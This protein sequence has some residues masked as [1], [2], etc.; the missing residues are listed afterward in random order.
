M[1]RKYAPAG[2]RVTLICP[3]C[4]NSFA[5]APAVAE[6]RKYCSRQCANSGANN[7]RWSGGRW[8]GSDGYVLIT[9]PGRGRIKEHRY[10]MEQMIGSPLPAGSV[11]HHRNGV[12]TDNRP[13]NLELMS[14]S[15]HV[16]LHRLA[17]GSR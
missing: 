1:P 2:T 10:V 17:G 5:L 13:E 3:H 8:I 16:R 6:R 4:G 9:V 15:E 14:N 11:V 7:R 12:I